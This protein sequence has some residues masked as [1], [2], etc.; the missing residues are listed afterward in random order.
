M[1]GEIVSWADYEGLANGG[2]A[3]DDVLIGGSSTP[4]AV[5]DLNKALAAGSDIDNP[6][7]GAGEGFPLRLESLDSTL[8]S[9][10]WQQK[11]IKFWKRLFKDSATNTVEEYNRLEEYGSGIAAF[12][13]EGDLPT[14]DDSTYSRQYTKI[15]YLGTTRRVTLV[16]SML[17]TAH[18]DAVARE[19]VNGTLWLLRQL[20]RALFDGDEDMVPVQFDGMEKLL[21]T[22]WGN[23]ALDD[24]YVSGWEDD[25]VIDLRGQPLTNDH[26]TDMAER[27]Q[28]EPNFGH[29]T[30]LW[31]RTGPLKD[32]AKIL[33][34]KERYDMPSPKDGIAGLSIKGVSTPFG[35]IA[36]NGD[37][38]I[39]GSDLAVAAGVGKAATRPGTPTMT[40]A[41]AANPYAGANT[42]YFGAGDVGG[43]FYRIVACSRYGKSVPLTSA[44]VAVADGDVVTMTVT[45]NGPDTTYYEVY[46]TEA[47]GGVATARMIMK[48]ART[49]VS[50]VITDL[51]RFLPNT[52]KSYML[53]QTTEVL[54]W[55]QL[56]PFTK[57]PLATID[58]S[59]R[60]MQVL[61]GALQI[62]K[63]LQ[64]GMFINIG[65]LQT[66]AYAP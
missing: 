64:N 56:A 4:Q 48:V 66:G 23:T 63:P 17:K 47:D 21:T 35:N 54:K 32:L 3:G 57:I 24:S 39:P 61:F 5:S 20:E 30:D 29:A 45:D 13:A 12:I 15:K 10:T 36:L 31:M 42:T 38:F 1:S 51:N 11:D 26:I 52:S 27:L 55:K 58:T 40:V 37:I 33:Y 18:G 44:Q 43:Y 9:V 22:A 46:R 19:S 65:N 6:G 60:W 2:L 41:P 53:T 8:F 62:M 50:Q 34:P 59:I 28:A 14:E 49:G 25:H 16:L 7:A